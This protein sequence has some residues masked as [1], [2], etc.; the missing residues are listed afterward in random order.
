MLKNIRKIIYIFKSYQPFEAVGQ[1]F[2]KLFKKK[3][4]NFN[5]CRDLLTG[6]N[7]LEIGGP[8]E[9]FKDGGILPIYSII[10][11]LDGV[12]FNQNTVWEGNLH[13]GGNYKI[14]NNKNIGYQYI[15]D[16]INLEKIETNKYDFVLSCNNLE[17]IANPLKALKE[18]IRVLKNEG[19]LLVLVPNKFINFDHK[20]DF[21][22]IEHLISDYENNI[23]EKDMTHF[24]DIF[25]KHDLSMD[26]ALNSKQEFEQRSLNNYKNRCLH[27]HVFDL[28]TLEKIFNYLNIEI[29]VREDTI[30]DF[31]IVVRK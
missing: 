16:A 30:S 9:F 2:R 22:S 3:I 8:S 24:K 26:L 6:K 17:H 1:V 25:D 27:H 12:N 23:T 5:S 28:K 18:W 19:I 4:K 7:G 31:L 11:S 13:E 21:T 15:C 20:R 29:L 10:K 14:N